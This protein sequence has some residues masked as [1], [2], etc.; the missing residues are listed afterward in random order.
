MRNEYHLKQKKHKSP[1]LKNTRLSIRRKTQKNKQDY[2]SK[3]RYS[4]KNNK[5]NSKKL[6]KLTN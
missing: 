3:R 5:N 2:K 6:I 1:K 4:K